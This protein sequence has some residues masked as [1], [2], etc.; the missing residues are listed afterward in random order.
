MSTIIQDIERRQLRDVP[1]FK[2]ALVITTAT[3]AGAVIAMLMMRVAAADIEA[4]FIRAARP[5]TVIYIYAD[6]G[7]RAQLATLWMAWKV[8]AAAV[9]TSLLLATYLPLRIAAILRARRPD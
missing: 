8:C 6:E 7:P 4:Q 3:L 9:V 2:T 5:G 1:R